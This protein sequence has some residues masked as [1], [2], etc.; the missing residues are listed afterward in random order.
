MKELLYHYTDSTTALKILAEQELWMTHT[1]YLNDLNEGKELKE[2]IEVHLEHKQ[3]VKVLDFLDSIMEAYACSFSED[4]DLLSQWRGY[5]PTGNGFSIGFK[6]PKKRRDIFRDDGLA[7]RGDTSKN[8]AGT[9]S[10]ILT[11]STIKFEK[12][13]YSDEKKLEI[14]MELASKIDEIFPALSKDM[15]TVLNQLPKLPE[16][17]NLLDFQQRL[18]LDDVW[19]SDYMFYKYLFKD[20]AFSEE[21][22]HRFY[23]IFDFDYKQNP[24]YRSRN[25]VFIP[26][27]RYC[28]DKDDISELIIRSTSNSED[29]S[30]GLTHFLKHKKNMSAQKINAFIRQSV[31]PFR[32]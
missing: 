25:G 18:K 3:A 9:D 19:F 8:K 30:K 32:D 31:I 12:C 17:S 6:S 29:V 4:G 21:K 11:Y 13:I 23:V 1:D 5:C 27:I 22:E 10:F 24:L 15:K 16:R 7:I 26:Y 20:K 14:S 2:R 28:F